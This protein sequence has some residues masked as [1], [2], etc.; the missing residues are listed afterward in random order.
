MVDSNV[1]AERLIAIL[2]KLFIVPSGSR[3]RLEM[4]MML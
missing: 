1:D 3:K 4:H 2:D